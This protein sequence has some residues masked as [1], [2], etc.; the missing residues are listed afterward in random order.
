LIRENGEKKKKRHGYY[1]RLKLFTGEILEIDTWS[2][3]IT[4]L[5]ANE[6]FGL[7]F[8]GFETHVTKEKYLEYIAYC[9]S[10]ITPNPCKINKVK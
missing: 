5:T 3:A 8:G 2:W 4:N 6:Y 9:K 7:D 1:V 10:T